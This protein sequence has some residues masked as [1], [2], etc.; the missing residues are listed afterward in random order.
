MESLYPF[1]VPFSVIKVN[2][3]W[4]FPAG[5]VIHSDRPGIMR[6]LVHLSI[7]FDVHG[8]INAKV[9]RNTIFVSVRI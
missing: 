3:V 2:R 9:V 8:K 7:S 6:S 1:I 4:I 5:Q